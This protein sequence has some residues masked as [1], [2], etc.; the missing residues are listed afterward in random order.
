MYF[1]K[2]YWFNKNSF[3]NFYL[4]VKQAEANVQFSKGEVEAIKVKTEG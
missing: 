4:E 2:N 1:T 3:N